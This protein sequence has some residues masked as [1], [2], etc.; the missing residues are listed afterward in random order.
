MRSRHVLAA[1]LAMALASTSCGVATS[2][3]VQTFEADDVPFGLLEADRVPVA[4]SPGT[5]SVV[6][7]FLFDADSQTVV[8]VTRE[9]SDP[10][11]AAI[12][13]ELETGPTDVESRLGLR[14]ALVDVQAVGDVDVEG[15]TAFVDL[16]AS[17]TALSGSDQI[18][19]IAQL[20]FTLTSRPAIDRVAVRVDG[21]VV[22][23][24][25]ADG[26]LT[27]D[28]LTRDDYGSFAFS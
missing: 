24:P 23:V 3:E 14:S 20:V 27:R 4:L 18:V 21:E 2:D 16:T 11:P 1:A 5:G 8:P 22:D 9:L 19:A 7:V 26:T 12:V 28:P 10:A 17:F 13:D 6:E 15:A 25:R